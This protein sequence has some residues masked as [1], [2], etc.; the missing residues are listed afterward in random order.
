METNSETV[1]KENPILKI[2]VWFKNASKPIKI[3][4]IITFYRCFFN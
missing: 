4:K 2:A 1:K 3:S